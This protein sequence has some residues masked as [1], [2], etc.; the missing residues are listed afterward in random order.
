MGRRRWRAPP[1]QRAGDDRDFRFSAVGIVRRA[2][3]VLVPEHREVRCDELVLARQIEPD[4]E[5]L[6]RVR[7][8]L[9]EQREHPRMDDAAPRG[10]PLHVATSE[11]S[12]G[13]EGIRVI[14]VTA[15]RDRHRFETAMRVL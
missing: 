10:E 7:L 1:P 2:W 3:E 14:D 8:A 13:T 4:L 11:A 15:P 9:L 6:D 12:G 5:E